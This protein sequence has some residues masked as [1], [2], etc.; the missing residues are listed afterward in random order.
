MP[1]ES[2]CDACGSKVLLPDPEPNTKEENIAFRTAWDESFA[3]G[4]RT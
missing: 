2:V 3:A 1:V 4:S